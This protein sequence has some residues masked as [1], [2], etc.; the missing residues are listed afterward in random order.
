[1]SPFF[2][3]YSPLPFPCPSH[4]Q[5]S[6]PTPTHHCP[7]LWILYTCPLTLPLLSPVSPLPPPLWSLSVC[8]LFL[9]LWFCFAHLFC[10]LGS[11]YRGDHI[12]YLFFTAWIISLSIMLSSSIHCGE[13]WE[14]LLS[15]CC[16]VFHCVNVPQFFNALIYGW[17]LR[18]FSALGYCK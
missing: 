5:S 7:C 9:C 13:G 16:I 12:W 1:M 3:H 17:A 8:S 4:I 14:F 6:S 15:F 11:T 18:L 10:W 2:F